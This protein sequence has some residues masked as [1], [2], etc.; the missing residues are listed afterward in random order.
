MKSIFLSP[1]QVFSQGLSLLDTIDAAAPATDLALLTAVDDGF[2]TDGICINYFLS[3]ACVNRFGR[4]DNCAVCAVRPALLL[5]EGD[6]AQLS[7]RQQEGSLVTVEYGSYPYVI[8]DS[9]LRALAEREYERGALRR[10]GKQVHI[11]GESLPVYRLGAKEIV[12]AALQPGSANGFVRLSDGTVVSEGE[13][14]FL[15][16]RPVRWLYDEKN[17]LL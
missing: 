11:A 14:V 9:S 4:E 15:E 17:G 2:L 1:E 3:R 10:T 12:R 7:R 8:L 6:E 13:Q 16:M 5:E